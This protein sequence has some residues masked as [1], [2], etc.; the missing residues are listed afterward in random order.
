MSPCTEGP[1]GYRDANR[2]IRMAPRI[3][4]IP[5]LSHPVSQR[6]SSHTPQRPDAFTAVLNRLY[7]MWQGSPQK[8]PRLSE[9]LQ[10]HEATAGHHGGAR[11]LHMP[12]APQKHVAV[13]THRALAPPSS[14]HV[15]AGYT[16]C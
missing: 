16:G 14:S 4:R 15:R 10:H 11:S 5:H 13:G 9:S 7:R 12:R 2:P 3:A 8:Q 1:G 6:P